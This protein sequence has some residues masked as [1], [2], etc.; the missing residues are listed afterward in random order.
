VASHHAVELASMITHFFLFVLYQ[1]LALILHPL[2]TFNDVVVDPTLYATVAS[3]GQLLASVNAALPILSLLAIISLY[4]GV[5]VTIFV[6]K[7]IMWL[8]KKIPTI[9]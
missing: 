3:T 1:A 5:E 9:N 2:T 4:V 6:Y 7:G 8:I